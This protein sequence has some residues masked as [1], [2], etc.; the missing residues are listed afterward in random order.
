VSAI[1]HTDPRSVAFLSATTREDARAALRVIA[2]AVANGT[3]N[4]GAYARIWPFDTADGGLLAAL[5]LGWINL[6]SFFE[7]STTHVLYFNLSEAG[8]EA[9][10]GATHADP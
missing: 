10:F 2:L 4:Y 8:I 6:F 5:D 9:M 7:S 3:A 1:A